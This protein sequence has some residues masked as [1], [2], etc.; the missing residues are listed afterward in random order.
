MMA[1]A[2]VTPNQEMVV[3]QQQHT[4]SSSTSILAAESS[5]S[6]SLDF[7]L[8]SYNPN[9]KG[10]GFGEGSEAILNGRPNAGLTDPGANEKEKQ[11]ESMRK[12]EVARKERV[13]AEK[14]KQKEREAEGKI[15]AK[16]KKA[17]ADR[18]MKGI[19]D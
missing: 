13:A 12:A 17:E 14:L 4:V 11:A 18:R 6:M 19:F 1:D 16:E 5:S 9:T 10:G 2:I 15:R 8:P 3:L 7:S